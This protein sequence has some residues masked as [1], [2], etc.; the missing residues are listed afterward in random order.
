MDCSPDAQNERLDA[1]TIAVATENKMNPEYRT[2]LSSLNLNRP[3][4]LRNAATLLN[5]Y[6]DCLDGKNMKHSAF[7]S[8]QT[9][10][11]P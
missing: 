2:K 9:N 11:K 4:G 1:A 8:Q 10:S 6:A 5:E 7:N 3:D